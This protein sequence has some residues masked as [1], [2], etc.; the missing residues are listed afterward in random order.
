MRASVFHS[1]TALVPATVHRD[2][3]VGRVAFAG[4]K[5]NL[6]RQGSTSAPI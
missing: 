6:H 5:D 4:S 2:I 1:R 3:G